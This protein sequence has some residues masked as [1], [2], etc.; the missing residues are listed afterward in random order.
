V[1]I[2][3]PRLKDYSVES[4]PALK[5]TKTVLGLC[6][7]VGFYLVV[8]SRGYSLVVVHRLLIAVASLVAAHGL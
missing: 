6:G 3:G 5:T 8:A 1:R 7:C 2:P 4:Y